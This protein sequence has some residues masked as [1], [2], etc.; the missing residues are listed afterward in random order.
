LLGVLHCWAD[1]KGG[2]KIENTGPL[3]KK[4]M[5]TCDD[6]FLDAAK[7]F[8]KKQHKAKTPF[9]VWFNT[10][11]MHFRTHAKPKSLGQSGRWQSEYHD[12]MID[13]DKTVG[14]LLD[15]LDELVIADNTMVI[16]STD[17]GPHC[18]SW[19]DAGT[20]PFRS[21]KNSMREGAYRMALVLVISIGFLVPKAAAQ[22]DKYSKM[23]PVDEYLMERNAEILL[24]RSAAPDSI[25]SDATILVLERQG[26]ETAVRGKNGFVCMVERSWMAAFDSPEFWNPKVKSAECLN[27]QAA[28][29]ILPIADLGT[30]MVMAG[31]SKAEIVSAI[32][33]AFDNKQSR[34]RR[35]GHLIEGGHIG[36]WLRVCGFGITETPVGGLA[37]CPEGIPHFRRRILVFALR[38]WWF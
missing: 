21:E 30:R 18:N 33:A 15:L 1:G 19:P 27:R 3:T 31:H 38:R 2:Q 32:K 37:N 20:T 9:F 5:E 25:S 34:K 11:H 12:A 16:Y 35:Y 23:A 36:G 6:E 17:N 29:S 28:R 7:E 10:T 14:E 4:R 22:S 26:Y 24:A 13:H 8:I